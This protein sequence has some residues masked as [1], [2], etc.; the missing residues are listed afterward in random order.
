M[1]ELMY[2]FAYT[3]CYSK[4]ARVCTSAHLH[5]YVHI[6]MLAMFYNNFSLNFRNTNS[7][8]DC[9]H[10]VMTEVC[11]EATARWLRHFLYLSNK[12]LADIFHCEEEGVSKCNALTN[13]HVLNSLF[14][15][16]EW[17]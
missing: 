5:L 8:L 15:C 13:M 11:G 16:A 3:P 14:F 2:V 12:Y 10:D 9:L 1:H 4:F 6:I 7:Y 17:C